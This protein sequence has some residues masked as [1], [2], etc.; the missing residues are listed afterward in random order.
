MHVPE[1]KQV[2]SAME[3]AA[4]R[5]ERRNQWLDGTAIGIAVALTVA[6]GSFLFFWAPYRVIR[7]MIGAAGP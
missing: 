3:Q 1:A 5:R 6:W 4:A 7:W 2:R